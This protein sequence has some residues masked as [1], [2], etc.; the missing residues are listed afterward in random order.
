MAVLTHV[1]YFDHNSR[2]GCLLGVACGLCCE[3]ASN[4]VSAI[5]GIVGLDGESLLRGGRTIF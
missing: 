5:D 1:L 2:C 3:V 4:V